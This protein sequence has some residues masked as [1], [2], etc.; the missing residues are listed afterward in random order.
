MVEI[1]YTFTAT[2]ITGLDT[3]ERQD[4]FYCAIAFAEKAMNSPEFKAWF[5][6]FNFTQL[7]SGTDLTQRTRE[8]L[9]EMAMQPVRTSYQLI[10]R[11]WWQKNSVEGYELP[12]GSI[13][14]YA[15]FYDTFSIADLGDN[16]AHEGLHCAGFSHSFEWTADRDSSVPY[17][18]GNWVCGFSTK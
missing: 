13:H 5:M 2:D 16:L 9:Y 4:K 14:D 6:S 11:H 12:D 10:T 8:E 17:A 1:M 3:P 18:C 15:D 7:D